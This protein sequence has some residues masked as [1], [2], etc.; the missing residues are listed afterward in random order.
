M[1]CRRFFEASAQ[2]L[3]FGAE[4]AWLARHSGVINTTLALSDADADM[5]AL[6][7][8]GYEYRGKAFAAGGQIT[9]SSSKFTSVGADFAGAS[10][11]LQLMLNGSINLGC[12]GSFGLS[13]V[14][15]S[16]HDASLR[17]D[18]DVVTISHNRVFF[19]DYYLSIHANLI[20]AGDT[21]YSIGM[22]VTRTLGAR[23]ST[24]TSA[25]FNQD[26]ST[27]RLEARSNVPY[28]SGYGYR[29]ST[30]QGDDKRVDGDFIGQTSFG[31]YQLY[32]SRDEGGTYWRANG[33]GS[34][35]WMAGRPY[36]SREIRNGFAVAKVGEFENVRVYVENHEV[37]RTDAHGRVLLP[38]LRPFEDNRVSIEPADLPLH[39]RINST[40]MS[41]SPYAGTGTLIE[42]ILDASRSLMLRAV[43]TSGVPVPEGSV[44]HIDGR[45]APLMVGLD[46]FVYINGMNKPQVARVTWRGGACTLEV[47]IPESDHPLPNI[48]NV[49]CED[50]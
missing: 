12:H 19:R 9:G 17:D 35:A 6:L 15:Q 27:V 20:K 32:A 42:F 39:V 14:H 13:Y 46:G 11:K 38:A 25:D 50:K 49:V 4:A 43:Q 45:D 30:T 8:L 31:R 47:P 37:G 36:F 7:S 28:G 21:D 26:R 40:R 34:V 18:A 41:A 24:S 2:T 1:P 22:T 10:P 48:G 23:K 29:V 44:V 33:T 3:L 16:Y 5:G